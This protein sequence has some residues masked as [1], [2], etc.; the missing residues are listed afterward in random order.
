MADPLP[1]WD[2]VKEHGDG[3][4][5]VVNLIARQVPAFPE[6]SPSGWRPRPATTQ[7]TWDNLGC[8]SLHMRFNVS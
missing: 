4:R 6:F 1:R 5:M 8:I 7:D 3:P 2:A